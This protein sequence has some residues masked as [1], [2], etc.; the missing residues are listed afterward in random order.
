TNAEKEGYTPSEKTVIQGISDVF[1][2]APGRLIISTFSSN[3]S[4]I[5]QILETAMKFK[6]K[7][8]IFGRS[9][10]SNID[11]A[12]EF[13]YIRIPDSCFATPDQLKSLPPSEVCILC[14]GTQGEPMA[15]LSRIGRGEHRFIHVLPG[16]TIVF[17]S[18]A[19]PGNTGAINS[20]I[21]QLTR[22]GASVITNSV[23]T[24]LHA[25][26]HASRQEM[27]LFQKL[28]R[29]KYFMPV[30]GEYRMLKLHAGI[31]VEC[32]MP[33]DHTFV[34]ENGDSLILL[35][36]KVT[37]GEPV[38][39]DA[40]YIDGKSPVGLSTSVIKDRSTLINEGMVGVYM[41]L[42][43]KGK[44]LVYTPVIESQG[45]ISSNK[46]ALQLKTGE[47]LGIEINRLLNSGKKLNLNDLK[48]NVKSIVSHYLYRESHRNPVI[49]PVIMNLN[50]EN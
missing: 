28:A 20:V 39:A 18:S 14:T 33:K 19:I 12:R 26:G 9:M 10:E 17:S 47:I 42:D 48:N 45:F 16:D 6:R 5:E 22:L 1:S 36:H 23:L 24:N 15:V 7:I 8:V 41:V 34:C 3:I 29:A 2:D 31:A 27:R 43:P 38:H 46:R 13:G 44:S 25:S 4:R 30:H 32:G 49:I 11:A 21:N 35:N 40:I 50:N 37:R